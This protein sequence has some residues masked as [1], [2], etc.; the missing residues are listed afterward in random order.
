MKKHFKLSQ[1]NDFP[2]SGKKGMT[3]VVKDNN[4][5]LAIKKL[6]KLI[7]SEGLIRDMKRKAYYESP[8]QIRRRKKSEA[9]HHWR[10][11]KEKLDKL[12]GF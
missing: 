7:S 5:T 10:K 2:F 8:G 3:I 11:K 9:I 4:V 1:N 12:L 6:K